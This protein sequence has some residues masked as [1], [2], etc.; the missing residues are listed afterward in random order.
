[1]IAYLVDQLIVGIGLLILQIP[2]TIATMFLPNN[3]L[4]KDFIFQYSILD[5]VLYIAG[6][7]YFIILTYQCEATLGKML[8]N[9]KVVSTEDR[10][11][12]LLEVIYRETIGR[13]LSGLILSLGYLLVIFHKEKRGIHDLL[14]DTKVVYCFKKKVV[15]EV[16]VV[17]QQVRRP[18]IVPNYNVASY[19]PAVE[20]SKTQDE[21]SEELP[22]ETEAEL[23]VEES[24]I[25]T[26]TP[27]VTENHETEQITEEV[28]SEESLLE[29]NV[30]E[31]MLQEEQTE[32]SML[33]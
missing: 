16:P 30:W 20:Q 28:A 8:L 12:T 15:V 3:M 14:S 27:E 11:L 19:A 33:E 4:T 1:M 29:G 7:V 25:E 31:E 13:F 5:I 18:V 21:V 24:V 22:K 23:Q 6:A 2:I 26:A 10:K 9:I 17:V 32:E